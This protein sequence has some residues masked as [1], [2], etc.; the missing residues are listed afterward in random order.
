MT[1]FFELQKNIFDDCSDYDYNFN[2]YDKI[3]SSNNQIIASNNIKTYLNN[4]FSSTSNDNLNRSESKEKY[5]SE[6][7]I[8][9]IFGL[10]LL[11]FMYFFKYKKSKINKYNSNNIKKKSKKEIELISFNSRLLSNLTINNNLINFKLSG[12]SN[13]LVIY[14]NSNKYKENITIEKLVKL[15]KKNNRLIISDGIITNVI[16]IKNLQ[17]NLDDNSFNIDAEKN[18]NFSINNGFKNM[19][20]ILNL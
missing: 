13:P 5:K 12:I 9:M 17:H 1:V 4:M 7:I 6:Y 2:N 19:S 3:N 16:K 14:K 18:K 8:I 15:I 20:V 10:I 11:L